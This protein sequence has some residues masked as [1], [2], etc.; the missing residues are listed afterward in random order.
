MKLM[1]KHGRARRG[2]QG[3]IMVI[4]AL[5]AVGLVGIAALGIDV[6]YIYWN[7]NKLQGG[8][9]AAA[10]AGATYFNNVTFVGKNAA[11]LY[12]TDA[13]NAACTYA[14]NNGILPSELASVIANSGS[15]SM[16]VSATRTISALFARVV[17]IQNFTVSA[18][19]VAVLRG[20]ASAANIAPLGLDS[21]T[22]Y[23]YGQALT[24]H[25]GNCG[26]GC[27]AGLSMQ[28]ASNGTIGAN[29]FRQN[30]G[31]GCSCT[32]KVGDI[33]TV[34]PGAK[35][36]P[37]GQGVSARVAAGNSSDPNGTWSSHTLTDA[38]VA[39]IPVV[40]W[41]GCN[42]NC[43]VPVVGFAEVWISSTT[44]ADINAVFIRQVAEGTPGTGGTDMGAVHA[45]LTQ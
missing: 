38:R 9:D 24:L 16:T 21:T 10:L 11:C 37:I 36:G 44:G 35:V 26:A 7:K 23:T 42:G 5:A 17:G 20:L 31:S 32:V 3:Q 14:L 13:Q 28:S 1:Q 40:N 43:S 41:S 30:L 12:A 25:N 6:F 8:T 22:T 33:L 45:Q 4:F 29:A 18:I 39:V 19:S 15:Q 34:E 2:R 27:W